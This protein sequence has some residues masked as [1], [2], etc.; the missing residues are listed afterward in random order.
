MNHSDSENS[1][2]TDLRELS[3]KTGLIVRSP[4][5]KALIDL[6]VRLE[7]YNADERAETLA[8]LTRALNETRTSLGMEPT[9]K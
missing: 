4:D 3:E 8:Y 1:T 9:F 5:S 7:E 2:A 6:F